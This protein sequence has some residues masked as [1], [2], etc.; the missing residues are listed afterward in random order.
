MDFRGLV[1]N[2]GTN[3]ISL[4]AIIG[5]HFGNEI[6]SLQCSAEQVIKF[7]EIDNSVQRDLLDQHV[8]D[9]QKY[10]QFGIDG[11]AI[12]FPP[13]ILSA[14]GQGEYNR[15][16]NEYKLNLNERLALLDGQHRLKAFEF[17]IKRLESKRDLQSIEQYQ[18]VKNFPISIQIFLDI[19]LAEEKQLF[20]DVNTKSSKANNTILIMY[21]NDDLCGDLVKDI[22]ENH[23]TISE[24]AF[25][26]RSTYTKTKMMTAATL[27]NI[28]VTLNERLLHTQRAKSKIKKE[29]YENYKEKI[30]LYLQL[31]NQYF[32][33]ELY[34]RKTNII[35]IPKVLSGIT[36]FVANTLHEN[37]GLSMEELFEIFISKIDWSHSNIE[38]RKIGLQYNENTNRYSVTD[39]ARGI[40]A[41]CGYL[42]RKYE[43]ELVK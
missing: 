3:H 6:L 24:D 23:P 13:I 34:S 37:P 32:P 5:N 38:F 41:I 17:V 19:S 33:I 31:L 39:G 27:H 11:N 36:L 2:I 29:T 28:I 8:A 18:F 42:I 4:N 40:K 25:E 30:I 15:Q 14:R 12:Y 26:I 7:I 35:Y 22:I 20:T 16:T 1:D 10:I 9:I 21:K 43:E